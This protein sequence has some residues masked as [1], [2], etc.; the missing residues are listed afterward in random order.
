MIYDVG[1]LFGL[2]QNVA[3]LPDSDGKRAQKNRM[4][5]TKAVADQCVDN[6]ILLD[7]SSVS[8]DD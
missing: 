1:A 6:F 8:D 7:S 2:R 3:P 5:S 4:K